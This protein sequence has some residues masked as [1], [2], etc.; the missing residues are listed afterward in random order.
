[1]QNALVDD[2]VPSWYP[3]PLDVLPSNSTNIWSVPV[4]EGL[5]VGTLVGGVGGAG[6]LVGLEVA[7]ASLHAHKK[8]LLALHGRVVKK[9]TQVLPVTL[10]S[11]A[12]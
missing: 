11:P 9:D 10:G 12:V 6:G 5:D 7:R 8:A 4:C 2:R 1:V 3:A